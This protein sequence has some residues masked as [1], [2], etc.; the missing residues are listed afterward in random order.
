MISL[1]PKCSVT[2]TVRAATFVTRFF[3]ENVS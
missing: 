1:S 3:Q 2:R